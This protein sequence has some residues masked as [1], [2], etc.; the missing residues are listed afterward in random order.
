MQCR[1]PHTASCPH[2]LIA[3]IAATWIL[4][5]VISNVRR[6]FAEKDR[7]SEQRSL[8]DVG[9]KRARSDK[10]PDTHDKSAGAQPQAKKTHTTPNDKKQGKAA[11]QSKA[12]ENENST[13]N[14]SEDK[15][16]A[17]GKAAQKPSADATTQKN[18]SS[19]QA[20]A[21]QDELKADKSE[22][23]DVKK[24]EPA[25]ESTGDADAKAPLPSSVPKPEGVTC[26]MQLVSICSF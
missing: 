22:Q 19:K 23:K 13:A 6:L 12:K 11:D 24:E 14:V 21:K 10:E 1:L 7:M 25:Q 2:L 9:V 26:L 16:A 18:E 8:E 15:Q 5:I 4:S 20:N 3:C 17:N